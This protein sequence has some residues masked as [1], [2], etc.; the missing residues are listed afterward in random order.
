MQK[1]ANKFT[2]ELIEEYL[3][4]LSSVRRVSERT[5]SAY[6]LDL[7]HFSAYCENHGFLPEKALPAQVR[8]FIADLSAEGSASVS[9]NRALSSIRGFYRWMMRFGK[10]RDDPTMPLRNLKQCPRQK[11]Q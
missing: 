10:R 11:G 9:V 2:I 8:G 3:A 6:G 1:M 7:K 4:Y 5:V